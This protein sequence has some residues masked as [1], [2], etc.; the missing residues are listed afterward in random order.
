MSEVMMPEEAAELTP[1]TRALIRDLAR[2]ARTLSPF[3]A[4]Y[5]VDLYYTLQRQRIRAGNQ[6]R[7]ASESG[8]PHEAIAFYLQQFA[9]LERS[10]RKVLDHYTESQPLS[11]WARGIVGIGP[12]IAAGLLS[13]VTREQRH[14]GQLW[15]FAGLS[16][17][18]VW[19]PGQKRPWNAR[20]KVICYHAGESF[21]KT[22]HAEG[23]YYGP[24][25]RRYRE[26]LE[27]MN[28][29]GAFAAKAAEALQLKKW[30]DGTIARA[31]YEAGRYPDARLHADARRRT[32]KVFLC[33]YWTV[34]WWLR[35]GHM[36]PTRP[37]VFEMLGH[38]GAS[39]VP[40]PNTDCLGGFR[41]AER[42]WMAG[43]QT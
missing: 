22:Q 14:V 10:I 35:T 42:R 8:E 34:S 29:A 7:A 41:E 31:A 5:L 23:S 32:V 20:L 6:A 19:K 11:S 27:Q 16:P 4:R 13:H 39:Y 43:E 40:A 33:H 18:N 3:E 21:I 30:R 1:P 37:Y 24:I 12:V 28:E 9:A 17:A 36:P 26:R 15:S 2:A 25:F 38:D